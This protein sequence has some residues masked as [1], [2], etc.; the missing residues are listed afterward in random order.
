[1]DGAALPLHFYE[2]FLNILVICLRVYTVDAG[3]LCKVK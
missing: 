3:V 2:P 1:M